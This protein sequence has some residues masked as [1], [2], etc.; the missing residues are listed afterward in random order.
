MQQFKSRLKMAQARTDAGASTDSAA[1]SQEGPDIEAI[2]DHSVPNEKLES[3]RPLGG[4][5]L[6]LAG[7]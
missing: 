3:P 1:I 2:V 4:W 6:G 7:N 5:K